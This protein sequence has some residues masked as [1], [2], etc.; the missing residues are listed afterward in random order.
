MCVWFIRCDTVVGSAIVC[1]PLLDY[2]HVIN[3]NPKQRIISCLDISVS[4]AT[5]SNDLSHFGLWLITGG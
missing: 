4:N 3:S 1:N 2:V 5:E